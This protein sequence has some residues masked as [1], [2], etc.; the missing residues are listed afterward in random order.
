M[1]FAFVLLPAMAVLLLGTLVAPRMDAPPGALER[2]K[3][4]GRIAT[5]AITVTLV[6]GHLL[7]AGLRDP[8]RQQYFPTMGTID[9]QRFMM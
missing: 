6:S 8:A 7:G 3:Q 5:F 1:V 2:V 4:A 9:L